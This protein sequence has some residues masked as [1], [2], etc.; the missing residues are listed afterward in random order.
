M[1]VELIAMRLDG[2][3]ISSEP[4]DL[5]IFV[6]QPFPKA[7][8]V[9]KTYSF[10]FLRNERKY[11]SFLGESKLRYEA[12]NWHEFCYFWSSLENREPNASGR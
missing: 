4:M 11:R 8:T 7:K 12:Y 1:K 9:G 6:D 2:S 5:G 3:A 10:M